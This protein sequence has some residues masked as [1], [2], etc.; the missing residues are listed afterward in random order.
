MVDRQIHDEQP[1]DITSTAFG[2]LRRVI[3]LAALCY[4]GTWI[5]AICAEDVKSWKALNF[6]IVMLGFILILLGFSCFYELKK[7]RFIQ[8]IFERRSTRDSYDV[9]AEYN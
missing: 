4:F 6:H 1:T 8:R 5:Y 3:I 9:N 7:F 2:V